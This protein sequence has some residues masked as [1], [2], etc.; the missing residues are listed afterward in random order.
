MLR[1]KFNLQ[2][3]ITCNIDANNIS[4]QSNRATKSTHSAMRVCLAVLSVSDV[5]VEGSGIA[6][7][8]VKLWRVDH[9]IGTQW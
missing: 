4:Y 9:V 1:G 8:Q 2:I 3:S 5:N 6:E 7:L